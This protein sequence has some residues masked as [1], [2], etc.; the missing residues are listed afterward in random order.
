MQ[1]N[2]YLKCNL[3]FV[4]LIFSGCTANFQPNLASH[5][6]MK[7]GLPTVKE[8]REGV[9]VSVEEFV[10]ANK[11]RRAFDADIAP[12][13]VL[14]LRV[15]MENNGTKNYKIQRE[16]VKAFL[17]GQPLPP[18]YGYEAAG[19]G[20]TRDYIPYALANT[21]AT[22]YLGIVLGLPVMIASAQHTKSIN[23]KIERHFESL[24]FTDKSLKPDETAAGFVYFK[25]PARL[26]TVE[27]LIV[28]VSVETDASEEESRKWLIYKFSLPTLEVS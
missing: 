7:A 19:Q 5:D 13:G 28:E 24:E 9:E 14:A 16:Q 3:A 4:G 25:L 20:A 15:R 2:R 23:Q 26:K 21:V 11:S 12:Y 6:L 22:G 10:S 17:A 1:A 27:N 8:I 18:I